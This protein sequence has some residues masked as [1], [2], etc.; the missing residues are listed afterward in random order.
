MPTY[1]L[2]IKESHINRESTV[3][4]SAVMPLEL[5]NAAL[6]RSLDQENLK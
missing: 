3:D 5:L 4:G 2:L 6:I 1:T